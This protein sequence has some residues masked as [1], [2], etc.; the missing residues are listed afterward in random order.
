MIACPPVEALLTAENAA[1]LVVVQRGSPRSLPAGINGMGATPREGECD[2]EFATEHYPPPR[3]ARRSVRGGVAP[4][5]APFAVLGPDPAGRHRETQ[6]P[7]Q[8]YAIRSLKH[9]L[10]VLW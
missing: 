6:R 2:M 7:V 4:I 5:H 1:L 10:A 8:R 3:D 9:R